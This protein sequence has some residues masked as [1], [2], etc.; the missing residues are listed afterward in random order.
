[1]LWLSGPENG[2]RTDFQGFP[3][4]GKELWESLA[5][6]KSRLPMSLHKLKPP[7]KAS[8]RHSLYPLQLQTS[9]NVSKALFLLLRIQNAG[10][11]NKAVYEV[12]TSLPAAVCRPPRTQLRVYFSSNSIK[13]NMAHINHQSNTRSYCNKEYGSFF[14]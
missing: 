4:W 6:Y 9:L 8:L 2:S 13:L 12:A 11:L 10:F 14:F 1:M 5:S 7:H 3:Y